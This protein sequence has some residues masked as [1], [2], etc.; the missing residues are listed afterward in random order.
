MGELGDLYAEGRERFI[1]IV[2]GADPTKP[3]PTCPLWTVKDTL[4]HV[5]GIPAD[6]L[7]GRLDGVATDPWT[8]AQVVARRNQ[9]I[10]EIVQ[11]WR[12]TGPEIDAM[13]DSFGPTGKQLLLDLTTHEQ[14]VRLALGRPALRDAPVL[15]VG[16][17]F[18]ALGLGAALPKA[19]SIE[20]DG[21]TWQAGEGIPAATLRGSRFDVIRACTG[22]RS[23]AQVE[24]MDWS[25]DAASL[26]DALEFG[27][28][29]FPANDIVE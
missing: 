4:A 25:G 28:F 11:E 9:S 17:D 10:A 18:L 22:R 13:V 15:D 8:E 27:P 14:D 26:V 2:A 7:A 19:L 6:I 29:T 16:L 5:A 21:R 3:V 23:R 24:A 20:A 1:G 12:E